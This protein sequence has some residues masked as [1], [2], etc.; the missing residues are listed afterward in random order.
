MLVFFDLSPFRGADVALSQHFGGLETSFCV[1]SGVC[2]VLPF[3]AV[4]YSDFRR[5]ANTFSSTW[6]AWHFLDV[7]KTLAGGRAW[8]EMRGGTGGHFFRAGTVFGELGR[9]FQR[10]DRQSRIVKP[11]SNLFWGHDNDS[12]WPGAASDSSRH[13]TFC[14]LRQKKWLRPI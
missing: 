8:N 4:F 10:V 5:T 13:N 7:A 12:M 1:T 11:S 3:Q 2:H 14:R 9:R 6:Q